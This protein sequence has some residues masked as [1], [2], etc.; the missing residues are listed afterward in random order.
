[1]AR[2][3]T[4][5][6]FFLMHMGGAGLRRVF[7]FMKGLEAIFTGLT[8]SGFTELHFTTTTYIKFVPTAGEVGPSYEFYLEGNLQGVLDATGWQTEGV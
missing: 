1:M 3:L 8:T 6:D 2:A 5:K 4:V 7:A